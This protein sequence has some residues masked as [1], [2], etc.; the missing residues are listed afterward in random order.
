MISQ[1]SCYWHYPANVKFHFKISVPGSLSGPAPNTN[2]FCQW[3]IPSEGRTQG[4]T[5]SCPQPPMAAWQS[6]VNNI[7]VSV[8][9]ILSAENSGKTFW[10]W[11]FRPEPRWGSSQCYHRPPSWWGG[12]WWGGG[13]L[14]S[15]PDLGLRRRFSAF[16]SRPQWKILG[17][18]LPIPQKIFISI[19][20]Q[21]PHP[22]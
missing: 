5:G 14:N 10:R 22:V 15:T 18:P 20:R 13:L 1:N 3:G 21:L 8:E 7:I 17:T 2:G 9:A 12:G 4:G 11:R 6:T 19:C 16:Q